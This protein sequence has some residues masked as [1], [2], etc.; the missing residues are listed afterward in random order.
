MKDIILKYKKLNPSMGYKNLSKVFGLPIKDL[1]SI[2]EITN[3]SIIPSYDKYIAIFLY[4]L[5]IYDNKHQLIY[6]EWLNSYDAQS[7]GK[8]WKKYEYDK[9]GNLIYQENA[10]GYWFRWGYDENGREI[11]CEEIGFSRSRKYT[12]DGK[13]IYERDNIRNEY[14]HQ[15]FFIYVK[16]RITLWFKKILKIK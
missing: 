5:E 14:Y 4:D 7:D 15:H 13:L 1:L 2:L 10:D 8:N 11:L 16:F 12:K 6:E 9:N 3:Y